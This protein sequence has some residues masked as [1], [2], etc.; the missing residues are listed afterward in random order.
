MEGPGWGTTRWGEHLPW[1]LEGLCPAQV[2]DVVAYICS[3]CAP[4]REPDTSWPGVRRG[5]QQRNPAPNDQ[6]GQ[7]M[8]GP[9]MGH[10]ISLPALAHKNN[11]LS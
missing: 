5:R 7:G 11:N 1:R 10:G 4:V 9:Y 3:V 8:Y 2:P 6:E